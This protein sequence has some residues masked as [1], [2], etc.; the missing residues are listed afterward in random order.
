MFNL[1]ELLS[2]MNFF[3]RVQASQVGPVDFFARKQNACIFVL[4]GKKVN[5]QIRTP[6]TI[7]LC[8]LCAT[9]KPEKAS[10]LNFFFKW[11]VAYMYI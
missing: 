9:N 3:K 8:Y 6:Q 1:A 11:T 5:G 4:S 7:E 2:L 10:Q